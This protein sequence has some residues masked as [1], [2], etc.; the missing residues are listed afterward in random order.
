MQFASYHQVLQ[1]LLSSK[2]LAMNPEGVD[3]V[4]LRLE[5]FVRDVTDIQEARTIIERT[6]RES[7]VTR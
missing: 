5:D 3:I 4:L 7:Y 2:A 6:T 1:E